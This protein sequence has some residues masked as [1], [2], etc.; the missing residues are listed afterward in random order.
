M[1]AVASALRAL[2][3]WSTLLAAAPVRAVWLLRVQGQPM[4]LAQKLRYF[5]DPE[6][7]GLHAAP[8]GQ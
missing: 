1:A 7:G 2:T 6:F 8:Q 5:A 3:R 4:I